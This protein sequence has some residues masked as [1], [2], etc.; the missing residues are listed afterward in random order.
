MKMDNQNKEREM[1]EQHKKEKKQKK[2]MGE[3]QQLI[4]KGKKM[5]E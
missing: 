5:G 1:F 4:E 3:K 2:K